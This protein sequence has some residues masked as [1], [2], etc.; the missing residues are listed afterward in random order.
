MINRNLEIIICVP[1]VTIPSGKSG[2][3]DA[4]EYCDMVYANWIANIL[5]S[6]KSAF[7]KDS[8]YRYQLGSSNDYWM[9]SPDEED[10]RELS[11]E[12]KKNQ[13]YYLIATRYSTK[14]RVVRLHDTLIYLMHLEGRNEYLMKVE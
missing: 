8:G 1:E 2:Y 12:P 5:F 6:E 11:L 4:D 13:K 7:K 9:D 14:E 10:I 3:C